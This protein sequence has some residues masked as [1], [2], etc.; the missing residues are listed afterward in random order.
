MMIPRPG[1]P[2]FRPTGPI[3]GGA[4]MMRPRGPPMF[5]PPVMNTMPLPPQPIQTNK[6]VEE[7]HPPEQVVESQEP[8]K[9]IETPV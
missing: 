1:A 5:R 7:Q 8:Q 4:P 2:G 6:I 3:G 9:P